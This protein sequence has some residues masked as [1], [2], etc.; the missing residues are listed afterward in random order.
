[1]TRPGPR[2]QPDRTGTNKLCAADAPVAVEHPRE[3]S[4]AGR[5]GPCSDVTRA[6]AEP[7]QGRD[8]LERVAVLSRFIGS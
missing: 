8:R 2:A 1:M 5:V 6:I 4:G 3:R 7:Q